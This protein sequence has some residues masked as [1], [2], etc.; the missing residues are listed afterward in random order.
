MVRRIMTG[1]F[2]AM[3]A[4]SLIWLGA[5]GRQEKAARMDYKEAA[6]IAQELPVSDFQQG[7]DEPMPADA[8]IIRL[9]NMDIQALREINRDVLGWICIGGTGVDYPLLRGAD[10]EHYLKY[11]W[12]NKQNVSGSIFMERENA[13]DFS[14]FN[15]IIYGHNMRSGAMFGGLKEYGNQAYWE[16]HPYIYIIND[17]GVFRYDIFAAHKVDTDSI[18]YAMEINNTDR[19]E[20]F[21]RFALDN[22]M[23]NT[24]IEPKAEDRIITL[25]T[26]TGETDTRWVVQGVLNEEYYKRSR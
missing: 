5:I 19:R 9:Q 17:S 18:V 6:H 26:C 4:V 23:V 3:L 15:T 12:K 2:A 20:E 25:S 22:S 10:N 24:G 11:D 1:I 21:I 7:A 8:E 14:D 16:A 13:A